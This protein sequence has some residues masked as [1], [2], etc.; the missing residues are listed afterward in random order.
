[1]RSWVADHPSLLG[2]QPQSIVMRKRPRID[3]ALPCAEC[4]LQRLEGGAS[5]NVQIN[6]GRE[7]PEARRTTALHEVAGCFEVDRAAIGCLDATGE[8]CPMQV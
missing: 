1:M 7:I 2:Q 5:R 8:L 3:R 4:A 6:G